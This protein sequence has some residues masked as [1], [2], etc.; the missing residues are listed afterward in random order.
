MLWHNQKE[1][2]VFKAVVVDVMGT[3]IS[4]AFLLVASALI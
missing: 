4:Q 2:T 3:D 1:K